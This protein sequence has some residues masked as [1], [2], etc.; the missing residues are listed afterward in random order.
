MLN[1]IIIAGLVFGLYR[2]RKII[3]LPDD[4]YERYFAKIWGKSIIGSSYEKS[5]KRH[6]N[7]Q[8][9]AFWSMLITL[10]ICTLLILVLHSY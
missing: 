6:K 1:L 7:V 3:T 10:I 8:K 5:L 9:V 2:L 4:E